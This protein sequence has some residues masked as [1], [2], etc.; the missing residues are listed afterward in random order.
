MGITIHYTFITKNPM[1]VNEAIN[2]A[3]KYLEKYGYKVEDFEV[4]GILQYAWFGFTLEDDKDLEETF[5]WLKK[6]YGKEPMI[7]KGIKNLRELQDNLIFNVSQPIGAMI[8]GDDFYYYGILW[9]YEDWLLKRNKW[10]NMKGYRTKRQGI[11]INTG[12]TETFALTF[13]KFH[14][15]YICDE[16]CKTQ[17]FEENE[18][19]P[20]IK[21]HINFVNTIEIIEKY[22]DDVYVEDEGDYYETHDVQK[23]SEAF[24]ANAEIIWRVAGALANNDYNLTIGGK[25]DGKKFKKYKKEP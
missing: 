12:T 14:D 3:K 24:G 19:L 16:F 22:M 17:P 15:Y 7:F 10:D 5:N 20:N 8:L 6:K 2:L 18:Y 11:I 4:E 1:K 13:Y 21:H 25:I 23:L 9:F